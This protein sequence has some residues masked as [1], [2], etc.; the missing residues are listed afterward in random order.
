MS[1][2][3]F[4]FPQ[5]ARQ[6]FYSLF[7]II[8]INNWGGL[9]VCHTGKNV[10]RESISISER[11]QIVF[12]LSTELLSWNSRVVFVVPPPFVPFMLEK[13]PREERL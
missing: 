6:R 5:L 8:Q 4:N 2:A 7:F 13:N 1:A 10:V 12:V 3:N 9:F 11:V